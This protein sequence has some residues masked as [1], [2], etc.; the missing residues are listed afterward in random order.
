MSLGGQGDTP[1]ASLLGHTLRIL[2]RSLESLAPVASRAS[3]PGPPSPGQISLQG[4]PFGP[5]EWARAVASGDQDGTESGRA[6]VL[7]AQ[8][9]ARGGLGTSSPHITTL[10]GRTENPR[11]LN[12]NLA[13]WSLWRSNFPGRRMERIL[14]N[15]LLTINIWFLTLKYLDTGL[16]FLLYFC[17]KPHK[18]QGGLNI[19]SEASTN[20]PWPLETQI[21]SPWTCSWK[22]FICLHMFWSVNILRNVMLSWTCFHAFIYMFYQ[23]IQRKKK[24]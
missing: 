24:V 5:G 6:K 2:P 7:A 12:T 3:S 19:R 20:D 16:A 22:A 18:W 14:L 11:T 8:G 1:T 23:M 13:C 10:S 21:K 9:Q 4:C 15:C 17:P